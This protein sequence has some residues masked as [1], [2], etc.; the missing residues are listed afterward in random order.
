[1][2]PLPPECAGPRA[3]F[4]S[5]MK[6]FAGLAGL[7]LALGALP[8]RAELIVFEDGR[9]VK[10][11]GYRLLAEE[12]EIAL[13]GGGSYRVDLSRVERIVDDEVVVDTVWVDDQTRGASASYDLSYRPGRGPLFGSEYDALIESVPRLGRTEKDRIMG[14]NAARLL[15]IKG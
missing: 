5:R 6:G 7:L 10:A 8:A 12:L 9:V 3:G 13:P 4:R 1:M 2:K 14:G 15:G 11:A